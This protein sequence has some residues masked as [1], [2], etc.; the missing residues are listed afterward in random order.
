MKLE[1]WSLQ[2]RQPN[3]FIQLPELA[4]PVLHGMVY[5]S[6]HFPD[7]TYIVTS[8]LKGK[9]GETVVTVTGHEY[10]VGFV[11]PEYEKFCP[12]ALERLFKGLKEMA[13]KGVDHG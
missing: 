12:G 7:G 13:G 8:R 2:D 4:V 10:E 6:D 3:T 11:N 1:Q 9:R 5:G